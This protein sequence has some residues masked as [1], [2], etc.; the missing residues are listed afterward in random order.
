[1]SNEK[2]LY[3]LKYSATIYTIKYDKH[4]LGLDLVPYENLTSLRIQMKQQLLFQLLTV[5]LVDASSMSFYYISHY[6]CSCYPPCC[7]SY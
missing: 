1:M 2:E 4:R 5:S 6:V 3:Y 7:N